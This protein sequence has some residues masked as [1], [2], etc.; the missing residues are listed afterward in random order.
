MPFHPLRI[1]PWSPSGTP[2]VFWHTSSVLVVLSSI[3]CAPNLIFVNF[4]SLYF[5]LISNFCHGLCCAQAET[6]HR[7]R[8]AHLQ[9]ASQ[10]HQ[11]KFCLQTYRSLT[12]SS[13]M[14]CP[15]TYLNKFLT[16]FTNSLCHSW[17]LLTAFVFPILTTSSCFNFNKYIWTVT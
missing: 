8:D 2:S 13:L 16:R 11:G 7:R 1:K 14:L 10:I 12:S 17:V 9:K 4:I 3:L 5:V 15:R 6:F